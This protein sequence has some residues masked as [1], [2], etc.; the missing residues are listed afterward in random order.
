MF[1]TYTVIWKD[2]GDDYMFTEV[3]VPKHIDPF[4]IDKDMW[5]DQ[6]YRVEY[7]GDLFDESNLPSIVGYEFLA[8]VKG[9]LDYIA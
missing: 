2:D 6:A 8:V 4:S 3:K 9:P 7:D 5:V 1:D